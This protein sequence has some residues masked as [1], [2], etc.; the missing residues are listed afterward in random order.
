MHITIKVFIVIVIF[1]LVFA[2][3]TGRVPQIL[4][5]IRAGK[6]VGNNPTPPPPRSTR[7]FGNID[8]ITASGAGELTKKNAEGTLTAFDKKES[9]E[10]THNIKSLSGID[11]SKYIAKQDLKRLESYKTL[12]HE[13]S[14]ETGFDGSLL[15][16]I[17]SKE[18]N[19]NPN[20]L[21]NGGWNWNKKRFG[22]LRLNSTYINVLGTYN[23]KEHLLQGV[24]G[25]IKLF[26]KISTMFPTWSQEQRLK[27]TIAASNAGWQHI[28]T[29]YNLIDN[30][31]E[32]KD[33]SNDVIV[34]AKFYKQHGFSIT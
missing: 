22:L 11:A 6:F 33:Y 4:P 8:N 29:D 12:I 24:E 25:Y 2:M 23:S 30:H 3:V 27:T 19:G 34:R 1:L 10:A 31:T 7:Y 20:F 28:G 16:A 26:D 21:N 13:V 15:A 32:G 5:A 14:K 18:C 17:I 9:I